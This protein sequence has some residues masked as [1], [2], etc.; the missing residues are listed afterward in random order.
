SYPNAN[1]IQQTPLSSPPMGD[2]SKQEYYH[3][4]AQPQMPMQQQFQP[5]QQSGYQ[6]AVPLA[7]LQDSAAPADCPSCHM[8]A[9]TKT[10]HHSG[11]TT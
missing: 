5:M 6:T 3:Q 1:P 10:E 7:N 8:R 11:N 4:G 2:Q 9:L